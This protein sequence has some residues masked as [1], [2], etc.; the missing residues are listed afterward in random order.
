[1]GF[2]R[3][4]Q[5][6]VLT[7][8]FKHA[9]EPPCV[10]VWSPQMKSHFTL[11]IERMTWTQSH[12]LT[13]KLFVGDSCWEGKV[14]SLQWSGTV[15]AWCPGTA[16]QHKA[17]SSFVCKFV[18]CSFDLPELII[19]RSVNQT[20]QIFSCMIHIWFLAVSLAVYSKVE[21]ILRFQWFFLILALWAST[22]PKSNTA[23]SLQRCFRHISAQITQHRLPH[24]K[25]HSPNSSW[26]SNP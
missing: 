18:V 8:Y 25:A 5:A 3:K 9:G 12:T 23:H 19:L 6:G 7:I 13:Q 14:S 15:S 1:M 21:E 11:R 2:C 20:Y 26:N 10:W 22:P 24:P 17:T 4:S 16:G